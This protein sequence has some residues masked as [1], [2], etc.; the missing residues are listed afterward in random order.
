MKSKKVCP[1]EIVISFQA[2]ETSFNE[3]IAEEPMT[4]QQKNHE[5]SSISETMKIEAI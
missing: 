1:S 5:S 4:L 2:R 3:Q